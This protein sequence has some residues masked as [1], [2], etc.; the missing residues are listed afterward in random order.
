M[1][2]IRGRAIPSGQ[3]GA[4]GPG[5][6]PA[7]WHAETP[8][9]PVFESWT[10]D[11]LTSTVWGPGIP[12]TALRNDARLAGADRISPA[13]QVH[14]NVPPAG[15]TLLVGDEVGLVEQPGTRRVLSPRAW[16]RAGH[17]LVITLGPA[18]WEMRALPGLGGRAELARGATAVVRTSSP[19]RYEL[20]AEATPLDLAL[21]LVLGQSARPSLFPVW[22]P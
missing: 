8:F 9:G 3:A 13:N 6:A 20:M 19:G 7:R 16:T 11:R 5:G 22:Y 14:E 17:E 4:P 15:L 18:V 2:A 21:A 12:T 1:T 10:R